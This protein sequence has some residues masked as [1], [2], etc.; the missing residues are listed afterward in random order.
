ML[1]KEKMPKLN[2]I[3]VA[4]ESQSCNLKRACGCQCSAVGC[5]IEDKMS[6]RKSLIQ[7]K[8]HF[9]LSPLIVL[10]VLLIVTHTSR[11]RSVPSVITEI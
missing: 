4:F 5:L 11:F 2:K 3:G 9:E 10:I 1:E 6:K 7:K 8:M